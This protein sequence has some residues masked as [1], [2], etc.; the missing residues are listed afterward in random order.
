MGVIKFDRFKEPCWI[1]AAACRDAAVTD[2]IRIGTVDYAVERNITRSHMGVSKEC[3]QACR[4]AGR[5]PR[6]RITQT[7]ME[8]LIR[9]KWIKLDEATGVI[10]A[11][12]R[13]TATTKGGDQVV[14][15]DGTYVWDLPRETKKVTQEEGSELLH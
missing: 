11:A 3:P 2:M 8:V 14:T 12:S 4:Q 6:E 10:V 5:I 9:D 15:R 1:T 13:I 7:C